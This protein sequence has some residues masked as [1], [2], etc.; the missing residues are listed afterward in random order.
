MFQLIY[1]SIARP[2]LEEADIKNIISI[3]RA[4]NAA[5][6]ITGCLLYYDKEFIQILEGDQQLVKSLYEKIAADK[7]HYSLVLMSEEETDNRIF[8]NW[9]MAYCEFVDDEKSSKKFLFK[10]NFIALSELAEKPTQTA[11]LFFH[12]AKLM[13]EAESE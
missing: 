12:V 11:R 1:C 6:D 10:K 7:R 5:H 13:L 4:Y 3:S 8:S 2:G 9:A